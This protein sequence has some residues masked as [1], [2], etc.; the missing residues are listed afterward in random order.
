MG[1]AYNNSPSS[2][3]VK[4]NLFYQGIQS[5]CPGNYEE[6]DRTGKWE[7]RRELVFPGPEFAAAAGTCA[8]CHI[9]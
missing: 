8:M 9:K 4:I 6:S 5:N 3:L 1:S 7:F 2:W